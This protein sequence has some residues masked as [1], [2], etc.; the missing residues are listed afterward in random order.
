[1][2]IA[3][4]EYALR[5]GSLSGRLYR[6]SVYGNTQ[7]GRDRKGQWVSWVSRFVGD[8]AQACG[9]DYPAALKLLGLV[10]FVRAEGPAPL[11]SGRRIDVRTFMR[12]AELLKFAGWGDAV[13]GPELDADLRRLFAA[14]VRREGAPP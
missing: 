3:Y 1:M 2:R 9:D 10:V 13:F 6:N 8:V 11:L 12:W 4:T 7:G 14:R 5:K